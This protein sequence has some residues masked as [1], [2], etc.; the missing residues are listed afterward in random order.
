MNFDNP[1][2]LNIKVAKVNVK[3]WGMNDP[4]YKILFDTLVSVDKTKFISYPLNDE[5]KNDPN[6]IA[7]YKKLRRRASERL[8][9]ENQFVFKRAYVSTFHTGQK[10]LTLF[11]KNAET[12]KPRKYHLVSQKYDHD[13]LS[14]AALRDVTVML[15]GNRYTQENMLDVMDMS[16]DDIAKAINKQKQNAHYLIVANGHSEYKLIEMSQAESA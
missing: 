7:Y 13:A 8:L 10:G 4:Y 1:I 3:F 15:Y 6:A 12:G 2:A 9:N 11:M 16:F 14:H 5:I